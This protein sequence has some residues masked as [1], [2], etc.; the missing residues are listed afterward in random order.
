MC[1]PLH[2]RLVEKVVPHSKRRFKQLKKIDLYLK[3]SPA[4]HCPCG[5]IRWHGSQRDVLP[6]LES[7]LRRKLWEQTTSAQVLE[8][9]ME[10]G[11]RTA[12]VGAVLERQK[13]VSQSKRMCLLPASVF[14]LRTDYCCC[15]SV[16]IGSTSFFSY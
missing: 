11:L 3:M 2:T 5:L 16:H 10:T 4:P 7:A 1:C 9:R 13:R 15:S 12:G 6:H 8:R 14:A